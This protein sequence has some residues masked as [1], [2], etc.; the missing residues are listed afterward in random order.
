MDSL[1]KEKDF[2]WLLVLAIFNNKEVC[3]DNFAYF[4]VNA[5]SFKIESCN[6]I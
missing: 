2:K 5:I 3:E 4:N 6:Y 1:T